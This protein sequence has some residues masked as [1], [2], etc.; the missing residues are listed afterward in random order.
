MSKWNLETATY[1]SVEIRF[2]LE[3]EVPEVHLI[4]KRRRVRRQ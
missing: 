1:L 2:G 3:H 4:G